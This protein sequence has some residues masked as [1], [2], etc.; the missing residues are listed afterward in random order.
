MVG[1]VLHVGTDAGGRQASTFFGGNNIIKD[2]LES[3]HID[4]RGLLDQLITAV[5]FVLVLFLI[6]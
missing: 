1:A 5:K 2:L 6:V 3:T 4:V